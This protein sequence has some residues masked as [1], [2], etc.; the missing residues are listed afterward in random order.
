M[1]PVLQGAKA[2]V[3]GA[4]DYVALGSQASGEAIEVIFP[5]SGTVIAARP[6]MILKSSQAAADAKRFIDFVLSN[7]GQARVA[8]TF[9]IPARTDVPSRR[10]GVKDIKA[11]PPE[12]DADRAGRQALLERFSTLYQRK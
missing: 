7:E 4:V 8:A 3:F 10:P 11:L 6:M 12:N 2:A 5:S 9:L 1:N